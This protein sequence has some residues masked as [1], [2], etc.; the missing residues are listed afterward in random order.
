MNF[1]IV[2]ALILPVL[3]AVASSLSL[4]LSDPP[5]TLNAGSSAVSAVLDG[6]IVGQ[7]CKATLSFLDP[8]FLPVS[9]YFEAMSCNG[10]YLTS[11]LI[12]TR[13]PNGDAY[14]TWF[15]PTLPSTKR[16][17]M[18]KQAVRWAATPLQPRP[19][20]WWIK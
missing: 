12:P 7:P 9:Y 5:V 4:C 18:V 17:L 13:T 2:T 3:A 6:D 15:V 19:H 14:V 20:L 1:P 11:I 16:V 8:N 10:Q